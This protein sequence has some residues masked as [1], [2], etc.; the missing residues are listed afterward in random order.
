MKKEP[1]GKRIR[2]LRLSLN[3]TQEELAGDEFTRGYISQIENGITKPSQAAIA[4]FA[5]R[6]QCSPEH[7][8]Q[9]E[10]PQGER[11]VR[12]LIRYADRARQRKRWHAALNRAQDARDLA[13]K[14]GL[15][16]QEWKAREITA[17]VLLEQ[18]QMDASV[19]VLRDTIQSPLQVSQMERGRM[20]MNLGYTL[21]R[22][23]NYE[24]ARQWLEAGMQRVAKEKGDHSALLARAHV[25]LGHACMRLELFQEAEQA[26]ATAQRIGEED[27]YNGRLGQALLGRGTVALYEG[28]YK[29]AIGLLTQAVEVLRRID[30]QQYNASTAAYNLGIVHYFLG[31]AAAAIP[32]FQAHRAYCEKHG[33]MA[34]VA[35]C[36]SAE[37]LAM[38][39]QGDISAA[40]ACLRAGLE[41][42]D[43]EEDPLVQAE[44]LHLEARIAIARGETPNARRLLKLALSMAKSQS[45]ETVYREVRETLEGLQRS[46]EGYATGAQPM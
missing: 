42:I 24:Q 31:D 10:F 29:D 32:I 30:G 41:A 46:E 14:W 34:D 45:F 13:A 5:R 19:G 28:R 23:G 18:G 25:A 8:N 15:E 20:E 37:G 44:L 7:L 33:R 17:R 4:I 9:E 12:L 27:G 26:F 6:L 35:R 21:L 39:H 22:S 38:L 16:R 1:I 2:R 43:R 11:V 40:E 3:M 36:C